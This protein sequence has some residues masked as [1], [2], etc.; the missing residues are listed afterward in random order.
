MLHSNPRIK[1]L[2]SRSSALASLQKP[3]DH[4][5]RYLPV[6]P[7]DHTY[8]ETS[9]YMNQKQDE[10]AKALKA[11]ETRKTT[12]DVLTRLKAEEGKPRSLFLSEEMFRRSFRFDPS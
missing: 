3:P 7:A 6:F 12:E 9:L 5:P 8:C 4:I 1:F 11:H 10:K 2:S